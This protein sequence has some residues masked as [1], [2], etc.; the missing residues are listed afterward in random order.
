MADH[1]SGPRAIADP[2]ADIADLFVFP[3][4]QR[5]G[6]LVLGLT[7]FPA[8]APGALFSDA[9]AYRFRLRPVTVATAGARPG[10]EVG[11]TEYV[12]TC[13]FA[14]PDTQNGSQ[15][16][17]QTGTCTTPTGE[18]IAFQVNDERGTVSQGLR[19][20][21]G[22]R[23][24]PFFIDLQGV[25]ATNKLRRLAFRPTGANTLEGQNV[26]SIVI[27]AEVGALFGAS[28]GSLFAV[29]GETVT[30]GNDPI[31][32]ER[33]GR[34]ELKNVVLSPKEFDPVNP[35]LEIRDLYNQ[36]DPFDL[37]KDYAAAYRA[38]LN[39]NLAFF[40]GLDG[41]TDWPLDE[42]GNHP[43]TELLLADYMVVDVSKPYA[44]ESC[45]EIERALLTGRAHATC[46]GRSLN[47]DIV[48][49]L[50]TLLVNAGNGPRIR[51]GVDQATQ[52]ASHSFPYLVRPNPS[53]P[54]LKARVAALSAPPS[55]VAR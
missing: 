35:D 7:V 47:D 41:K 39:A 53:P 33:F 55:G 2:A 28:S 17:V 37:G 42:Q 18:Q 10:F 8:A 44:E 48:D 16:L 26:L 5:P 19:V 11:K 6:H 9:V 13:T 23:L 51:D 49:S 14:A 1:F 15:A 27:E 12:L 43:L 31:R 20:F 36:E 21:A 4:P 30:T 3:S 34:P 45:Y 32:L 52:P 25:L 24:D 40:D 46:G 50:Y 54:D 22:L 38:R 29:V